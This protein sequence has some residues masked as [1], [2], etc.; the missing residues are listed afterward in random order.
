MLQI[1]LKRLSRIIRSAELG[2]TSEE[3]IS[4]KQQVKTL[5]EE[6]FGLLIKG[7]KP[8]ELSAVFRKFKQNVDQV[9]FLLQKKLVPSEE[10]EQLL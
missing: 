7:S 9:I 1:K 2:L 10:Q 8:S 5:E 3:E 4:L 6:D